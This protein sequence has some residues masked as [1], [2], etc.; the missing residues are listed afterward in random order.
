MHK[1]FEYFRGRPVIRE[2]DEN[3][4]LKAAGYKWTES[5]D[6][7][8]AFFGLAALGLVFYGLACALDKTTPSGAAFLFWGA[9]VVC[10]LIAY[11]CGT[12][13]RGFSF[14]RD[15]RIKNRAG[16]IN[17]LDMIRSLKEHTHISSIEIMKTERGAAVAVYTS[18]GGT[19]VLSNGLNE[20]HARLICVQL[21]IALRELRESMASIRSVQQPPQ[22]AA[23][24]TVWID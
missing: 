5:I 15:G 19:Y 20:V 18:W 16:W 14:E 4:L 8:I 1:L 21:T 7:F 24:Q 9:S 23:Q 6:E 2:W 10:L 22:G 3:G 11:V 17:K 12:I 13:E